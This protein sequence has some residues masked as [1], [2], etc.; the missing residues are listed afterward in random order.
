MPL[1]ELIAGV[2][3][4]GVELMVSRQQVD[5]LGGGADQLAR[6]LQRLQR[7]EYGRQIFA[8]KPDGRIAL[9]AALLP[10]CMDGG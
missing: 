9:L 8:G 1:P 3:A 10:A 4:A 5:R 7:L 2:E 6:K